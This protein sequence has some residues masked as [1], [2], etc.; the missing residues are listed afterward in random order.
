MIQFLPPYSP[1]LNPI[2]NMFSQWKEGVRKIN[3]QNEAQLLEYIDKK[4]EY[5]TG[6][7]CRNYYNHMLSYIPR[8]R[9]GEEIYD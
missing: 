9:D 7:H 3:P 6:I 2:E 5:I 1:F 8:C 4:F